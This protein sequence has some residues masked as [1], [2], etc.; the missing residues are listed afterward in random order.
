MSRPTIDQ[1]L[2]QAEILDLL[3]RYCS[4][5]DR[6]EPAGML[7][8]FT[9]DCRVSYDPA[10]PVM[11]SRQELSDML[12]KF[13]GVTVSGTHYITN[14]IFEFQD[15]DEVLLGCYMYSW[16]RFTGW[17]AVSDVHRW[18]RYELRL[19][20]TGEGWRISHMRLLSAGEYGGARIG[21]QMGR[22]PIP[23]MDW[24]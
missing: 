1:L 11:A 2:D 21:E 5:A 23:M 24:N 8:A 3:Y 7:P 19:V 14:P 13:L 6:S 9:E 17:P 12:Y 16:Q 15:T 4:A 20:R 22:Q 18:G 10:L